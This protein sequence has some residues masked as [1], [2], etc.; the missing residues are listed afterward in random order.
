MISTASCSL[1]GLTSHAA[2]RRQPLTR[3]GVEEADE[4]I[5]ERHMSDEPV[6]QY[7]VES[8]AGVLTGTA[9]YSRLSLR[10]CASLTAA[11]AKIGQSGCAGVV[12]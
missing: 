10:I 5:P 6:T 11:E 8:N 1:S 3:H 7:Q 4:L 9:S 2:L 12:D